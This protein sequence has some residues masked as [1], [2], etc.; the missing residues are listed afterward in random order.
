[1]PFCP[2]VEVMKYVWLGNGIVQSLLCAVF[3]FFG[4]G[5][6]QKNLSKFELKKAELPINERGKGSKKTVYVALAFIFL[7]AVANGFIKDGVTAWVP[8][9]LKETY[10]L[11][12]YFSII[13]TLILPLISILGA[14]AAR[15]V[16]RK[17]P[18]D[19]LLCGLFYLVGGGIT[20]LIVW[21]LTKSLAATI[22]LFAL[23]SCSM[24]AINNVITSSMPFR[25]R[26]VGDSG[27]YAGVIN[28]FCYVGSTLSSYLL[29]A[30]AE[31]SGWNTVIILLLAVASATGVIATAFSPFWHKKISPLIHE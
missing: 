2:G 23:V 9:L 1:M 17:L 22:I 3:W 20:G 24:A 19:V 12:T 11:E 28:T 8:N 5:Y 15:L 14:V 30:M 31:R 13:L 4:V 6:V 21:L 27:A 7:F 26:T 29:G 10:G 16:H 25:L 18:N